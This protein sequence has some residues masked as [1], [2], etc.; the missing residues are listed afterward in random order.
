M[1]SIKISRAAYHGGDFNGVCCRRIV[2]KS[3]AIANNIQTILKAKKDERCD[4]TT[5]NK[6]IDEVQQLLGLLDAAFAYL[7]IF[8]PNDIKKQQAREAVNALSQY[9]RKLGMA[10]L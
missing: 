10:S 7:N 9:W 4:D 3:K 8:Y 2:R 6:K 5:I 1:E